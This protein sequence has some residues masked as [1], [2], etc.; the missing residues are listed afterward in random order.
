[1]TREFARH[2]SHRERLNI[3]KKKIGNQMPCKNE[4]MWKP[5]GET[6][7][8]LAL[9]VLEELKNSMPRRIADFIQAK[10]DTKKY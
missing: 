5:V 8:S 7:Y 2:G 9:N 6:W 3:I 10:G 1:M 4:E